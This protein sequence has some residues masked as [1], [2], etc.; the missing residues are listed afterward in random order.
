VLLLSQTAIFQQQT[1][2][3]DLSCQ[4]LC[5]GDFTN[6]NLRGAKLDRA[7]FSGSVLTHVDFTGATARNTILRDVVWEGSE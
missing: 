5:N 2:G 7:D 6:L 4:Y 1:S 3:L